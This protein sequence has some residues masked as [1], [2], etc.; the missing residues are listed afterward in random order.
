MRKERNHTAD[1]FS[2]SNALEGALI[3]FSG[4]ET[5]LAFIS[6]PGAIVSFVGTKERGN[7][8]QVRCLQRLGCPY[9]QPPPPG[10][11]TLCFSPKLRGEDALGS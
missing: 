1:K 3:S 2:T 6:Q 4:M 11:K 5:V 9:L 7:A 8:L 10:G